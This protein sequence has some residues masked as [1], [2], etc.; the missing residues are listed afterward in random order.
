LRHARMQWAQAQEE[1]KPTCLIS[2]E[3]NRDQIC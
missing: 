2:S 3:S 1:K